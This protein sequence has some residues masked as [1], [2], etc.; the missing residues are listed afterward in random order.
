[1]PAA[2]PAGLDKRSW[3]GRAL[4]LAG[5]PNAGAWHV[6]SSE[7]A[8]L[9]SAAKEP[10][11][12]HGCGARSR[13]KCRRLAPQGSTGPEPPPHRRFGFAASDTFTVPSQLADA[14]VLPS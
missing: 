10:H 1:C 11:P 2:R 12:L 5:A 7:I 8:S 13:W 14:I 9:R 3:A 6:S 4:G